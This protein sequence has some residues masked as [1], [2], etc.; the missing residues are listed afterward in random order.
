MDIIS[1]NPLYLAAPVLLFFVVI[2]ILYTKIKGYKKIY[3]WKD[4]FTSTIMSISVVTLQ[5]VLKLISSAAIF[6]F[7]FDYFNPE[8]DEIYNNIFG[9]ESFSWSW[10]IWILCLLG[11]QLSQYWCHRL[12]HTIRVLWAAHLVHHSSNHFN[13]GTA[14]RLSWIA[15]IYKPIFYVW[16]P[17]VGFHPEMVIFCMA[18]EN[19]YQFLLHSAYC[20][21]LKY[22]NLVFVTPKLH[23]VH[24]AKNLK[25]LDKNHGAIFSFYDRVF[26]TYQDY[27][28][29][30][31]I[32]YGITS[33]INS[34][35]PISIT[36]H[37][38]KR[39]FQDLQKSKCLRNSFM[40]VFGP[41]GWSPDNSTLT[42]RQM[43]QEV[44]SV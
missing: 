35:N 13:F 29:N 5:P 30:I 32:E 28:E 27:D 3:Y 44:I 37:E 39:I 33:K 15:M 43:Q 19:V 38:F 22:V 21:K 2:E 26:G 18:I 23:Q 1:Y 40:Y 10:N 20:P 7:L 41:P 6:Y 17:I 8:V 42:V 24:H 12:N 9:Y 31:D 11:T 16:L 14:L 34:L 36:T 25:Y 4:L